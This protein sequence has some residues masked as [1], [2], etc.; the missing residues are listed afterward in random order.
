MGFKYVESVLSELARHGVIPGYDT[1]PELVHEFISN[2]YL[3]EIRALKQRLLAGEIR[4]ADY[5]QHV[6]SLR[7]RYP[8]LSLPIRLWCEKDDAT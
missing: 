7:K 2:L 4:M 8:V 6:E 5:A 1:P 3:V